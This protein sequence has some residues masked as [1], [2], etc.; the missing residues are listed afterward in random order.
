M[1]SIVKIGLGVAIAIVFPL[2]VGLGIEAFYPSPKNPYELC[3][4]KLPAY[5][6]AETK[7]PEADPT[8]K[9]CIEDQKAILNS[10]NRN[11]FIITTI[12]GFVAISAGA[13]YFSESMG[14]ASP[15]VVFGGLLTILYGAIRSFEAVD[16]R[17]LF[18][19]LLIVLVGLIFVT[20]RYI[21]LTSKK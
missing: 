18:L 14:P 17:W 13:L 8:Y 2:M 5:R 11:L 9:K 6:E 4:E 7:P 3:V 1:N 19:E 21:K 20:R 16:K 15:G 10:Y 12:I